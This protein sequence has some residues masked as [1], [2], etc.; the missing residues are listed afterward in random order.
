MLLN[1][2]VQWRFA[3]I[4]TRI[5]I[6]SVFQ[7]SSGHLFQSPLSAHVEWTAL[8]VLSATS[9]WIIDFASTADEKTSRCFVTSIQGTMEQR[10]TGS[11]RAFF[12]VVRVDTVTDEDG[13]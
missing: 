2:C 11:I 13:S 4:V 5:D 7:Q 9:P 10:L 8:V 6:G 12:P 1:G 3:F